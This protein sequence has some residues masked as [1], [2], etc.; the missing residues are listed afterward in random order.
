MKSSI[1]KSRQLNLY[2]SA[3]YL[4]LVVLYFKKHLISSFFKGLNILQGIDLVIKENEISI[5][6]QINGKTRDV[7]NRENR[8][9]KVSMIEGL[10]PT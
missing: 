5:V 3:I 1:F 10:V 4:L 2:F 7:L 9:R 8:E 6:V